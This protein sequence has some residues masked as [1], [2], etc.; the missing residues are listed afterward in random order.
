MRVFEFDAVTESMP[1]ESLMQVVKEIEG[2]VS[3]GVTKFQTATEWP[4]I[5]VIVRPYSTKAFDELHE[6]FSTGEDIEFYE[7]G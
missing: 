3:V 6:M 2:V 4:T 7:V 5:N 1:I